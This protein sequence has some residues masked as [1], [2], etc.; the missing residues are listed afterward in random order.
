MKAM[1]KGSDKQR[2]ELQETIK[3]LRQSRKVFISF[4]LPLSTISKLDDAING[5]NNVLNRDALWK[6][7]GA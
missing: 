5:I 4:G 3:H 1:S 2:L 7:P 6:N